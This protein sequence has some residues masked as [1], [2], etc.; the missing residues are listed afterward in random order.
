MKIF[1]SRIAMRDLQHA[2][3]YI[4]QHN[5]QAAA[6]VASKIL[7]S[8]EHLAHFPHVGR[9]GRTPKTRELVIGSTPFVIPYT[10]STRGVE[11]I[12]VLHG[13]RKWPD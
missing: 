7:E 5:S 12:A 6:S 1:W 11:I 2:R 9:P 4:E 13:A 8:V 3:D 10:V